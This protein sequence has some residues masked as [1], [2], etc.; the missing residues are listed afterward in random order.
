VVAV[1][2]TTTAAV[3]IRIVVE[4]VALELAETAAHLV[5][6]RAPIST[7]RQELQ[8]PVVAVV[9]PTLNQILQVMVDQGSSSCVTSLLP[10]QRT[11]VCQQLVVPHA[12][13]QR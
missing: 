6:A 1:A 8:T 11:L 12:Q 9:E 3:H 4:S 13:A 2:L 5:M 7:A 10:H